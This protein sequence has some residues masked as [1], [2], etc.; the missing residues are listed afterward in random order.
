M[1]SITINYIYN[2]NVQEGKKDGDILIHKQDQRWEVVSKTKGSITALQQT[3]QAGQHNGGKGFKLQEGRFRWDIG[4]EF[5][6]V[7]VLR[8]QLRLS[9]GAVAAPLIPEIHVG[10]SL[11]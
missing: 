2:S 4:K 3:P 6:P 1:E 7:R 9:R 8:P 11:E 10:Q 5:S